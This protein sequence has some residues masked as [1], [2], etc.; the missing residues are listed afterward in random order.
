MS[1]FIESSSDDAPEHVVDT[2]YVDSNSVDTSHVDT[3]SVSSE[4]ESSS[5]TP[6]DEVITEP[7][8]DY[9][10][11]YSYEKEDANY[12][13]ICKYDAGPRDDYNDDMYD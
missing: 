11:E 13:A 7:E 1:Q 2:N 3:S 5:S 10:F 8:S 12:E 6:T 4:K 9:I